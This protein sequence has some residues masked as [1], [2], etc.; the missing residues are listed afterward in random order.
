L[1]VGGRL[2]DFLDHVFRVML[3]ANGR[4]DERGDHVL[5]L[6]PMGRELLRDVRLLLRHATIHE[7]RAQNA[8]ATCVRNRNLSRCPPSR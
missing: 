8:D 3:I 6:H 2:R 1:L 4:A 7:N 5:A